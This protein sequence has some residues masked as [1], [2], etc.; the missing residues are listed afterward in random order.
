MRGRMIN[1]MSILFSCLYL[2]IIPPLENCYLKTLI[3]R[4]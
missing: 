3:A 2:S 1:G 4:I